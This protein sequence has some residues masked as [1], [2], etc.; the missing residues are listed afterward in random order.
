MLLYLALLYNNIGLL[1]THT[2]THITSDFTILQQISK[3]CW[4]FVSNVDTKVA[5]LNRLFCGEGT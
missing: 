1:F 5:Y 4:R 2:H 3:Q